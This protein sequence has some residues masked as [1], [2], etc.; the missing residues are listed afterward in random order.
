LVIPDQQV[1]VKTGTTNDMRD[2]WTFGY[3]KDY[4][5][6]T[7][8]GNNDN[9]PMSRVASGIT[10]ASPIWQ[11]IMLKLYE[12]QPTHSFVPPS[13]VIKVSVCPLT[14]T[15]FCG[16][17]PNPRYDYYLAGTEPK[18]AC[19]ADQILQLSSPSPQQLPRDQILDGVQI[20]KKPND[21]KPRGRRG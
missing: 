14:Q 16:E 17:C 21:K 6:A 19:T 3:T 9:T 10:G 13:D 11:Q 7:W 5:V 1:A 8:V 4:L 2:N 20:E 18:N 12:G 15:L